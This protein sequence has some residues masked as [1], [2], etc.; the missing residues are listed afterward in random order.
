M[1]KAKKGSKPKAGP[2]VKNDNSTIRNGLG[3]V[4]GYTD[5]ACTLVLGA[6]SKEGYGIFTF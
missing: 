1:A 4:L 3:D 5:N 6:V 2:K